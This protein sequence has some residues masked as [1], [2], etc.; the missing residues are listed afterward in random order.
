MIRLRPKLFRGRHFQ[1]EIIILCIRWYLRYSLS[2]RDLEE[3]MAERGL[4]VDHSTVARWVL[5]YA[6]ELSKRMRRHLRRPGSSWRVDETYVRVAGAWTY[7]YRAIDSQ[8]DTIDFMLSPKRDLVA[9]K[10]FLRWALW[11]SDAVRPRVINVDGHPAYA[12]A[13][14][15]LKESGE[16]GVRCRCRPVA[17]LNNIVEQD[18]RFIKKRIAASLWFRSVKRGGEYDCRIRVDAHDQKRAGAVAGQ[19]RHC[20][21]GPIHSS[22]IRHHRVTV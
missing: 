19:G 2:Y 8:G 7:L 9:A 22:D 17:Y 18:H 5:R 15:D 10:Q 6:P 12:R 20:R 11:R 1:D 14:A 4:R 16:L 13:I 3:M 21:P